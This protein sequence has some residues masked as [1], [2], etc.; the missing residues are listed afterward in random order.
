ML[1]DEIAAPVLYA[2][3]DQVNA[4]VPFEIADRSTVQVKVK[5]AG[6]ESNS[7]EL[8]VVDAVAGVF[9]ST[10]RGSG[11]TANLNQGAR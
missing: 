10:G 6:S 4:Q 1:F 7:I 3:S 5:Y 8:Q 2:A 9:T 11:Q